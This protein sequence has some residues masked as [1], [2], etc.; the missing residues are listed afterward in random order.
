MFSD[1]SAAS[2]ISFRGRKENQTAAK[3]RRTNATAQSRPKDCLGFIETLAF[4]PWLASSAS[5]ILARLRCCFVSNSARYSRLVPKQTWI[6]AGSLT[7]ALLL[8]LLVASVRKNNVDTDRLQ[9][10]F[11]EAQ[12]A[13]ER[14]A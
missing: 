4:S 12:S 10:A 7:A 5:D 3:T 11:A 2:V 8:I 1:W 9:R 6:I 14:Q 13:L